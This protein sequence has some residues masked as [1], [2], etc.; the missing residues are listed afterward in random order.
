MA[1]DNPASAVYVKN[2]QKKADTLG[3]KAETIN[4][5]SEPEARTF[6][7]CLPLRTF[8]SRSFERLCSPTT[9]P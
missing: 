5:K 2:K 1:G 6:V 4:L 3:I 8:T 7:S 9:I